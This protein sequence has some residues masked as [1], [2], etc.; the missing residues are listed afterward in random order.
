MKPEL[1]DKIILTLTV[2]SLYFPIWL[3]SMLVSLNLFPDATGS[4]FFELLAPALDPMVL[5]SFIASP[6]ALYLYSESTRKRLMS[7]C[8]ILNGLYLVFWILGIAAYYL[9]LSGPGQFRRT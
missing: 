6:V 7:A 1:Y 8:F 5:I 2:P 9:F 3:V 4:R